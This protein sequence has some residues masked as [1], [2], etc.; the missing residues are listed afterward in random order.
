MMDND[1]LW[2]LR[3]AL[4]G[5][6]LALVLSV[7]IAASA[8]RW[9]G[10][11]FADSYGL[12]VAIYSGLLLY[13]VA[14]AVVLFMRVAQHETRPMSAGRLALWLAS[15]WLWPALLLGRKAKPPAGPGST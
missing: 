14:G 15:L 9:I 11:L 10:D 8:G 3:H 1:P 4:I 7:V 5:L 12:R 6:A 2:K 13:V